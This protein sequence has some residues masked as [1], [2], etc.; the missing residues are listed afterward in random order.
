MLWDSEVL[1]GA[2]RQSV[3]GQNLARGDWRIAR[4]ESSSDSDEADT[5]TSE[6]EE[7]EEP[8]EMEDG[9]EEVHLNPPCLG[10][11]LVNQ[12]IEVGYPDDPDDEDSTTSWWEVQVMEYNHRTQKYSLRGREHGGVFTI[13]FYIAGIAHWHIPHATP[14]QL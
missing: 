10:A 12:T 3:N 6:R 8:E 1:P 5:G 9:A 14:W 13:A 11:G 4:A 2:G 7:E